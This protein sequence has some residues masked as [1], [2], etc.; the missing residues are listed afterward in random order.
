[1]DN[2]ISPPNKRRYASPPFWL[3]FAQLLDHPLAFYAILAAGILLRL[4]ALVVL[5]AYPAPS[6]AASY[7]AEA[8]RLAEGGLAFYWPPGLPL[9]LA[10]FYA[11]FGSDA[12]VGQAAMLLLYGG[13]SAA[14]WL[15]GQELA[16]RRAANLAT[17]LF[18]VYPAFIF[19]SLRTLTQAPAALCL[20]V[21]VYLLLRSLRG[22][23]WPVW[24]GLGLFTGVLVLTRTSN[25]PFLG[26]IPLYL[27]IRRRWRAA[28][29]VG[30]SGLALTLSWSVVAYDF[31]GRF[32]LVNHANA[33]NFFVGNNP[34]TDSYRTWW[35]GSHQTVE[36]G[37]PEG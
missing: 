26:L 34:Y 19:Y 1:M 17:L 29:V 28:L 33:R 31:T 21:I 20:V 10:F 12:I 18:A 24:L 11:L 27:V 5:Q 6:D 9:Y 2:S 25:L 22:A 16:G 36:E 32:I 3:H 30:L 4:L 23:G 14:V 37:A 15:L 8:V 7:H 13:F 35:F